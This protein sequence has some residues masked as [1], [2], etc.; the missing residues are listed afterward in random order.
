[1]VDAVCNARG[2]RHLA[3]YDVG[4]AQLSGLEPFRGGHS[5]HR[6]VMDGPEDTTL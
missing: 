2:E 6:S 4:L 5:A 3:A 1:V